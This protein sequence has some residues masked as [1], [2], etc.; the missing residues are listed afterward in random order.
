MARW[1]ELQEAARADAGGNASGLTPEQEFVAA[2]HKLQARLCIGVKAE[3]DATKDAVLRLYR[4]C[5]PHECHAGPQMC[6]PDPGGLH[7]KI[8]AI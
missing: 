2:A 7:I 4:R 3:L 5:V 8:I 1:A 6:I